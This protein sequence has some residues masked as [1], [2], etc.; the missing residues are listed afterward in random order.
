MQA[1]LLLFQLVRIHRYGNRRLSVYYA[2]VWMSLLW[3]GLRTYLCFQYAVHN[4]VASNLPFPVYVILFVCPVILQFATFSLVTL[5]FASVLQNALGG[6]LRRAWTWLTRGAWV[7]INIGVASISVYS[8]WRL[9]DED[10]RPKQANDMRLRVL[11]T[12]IFSI[13]NVLALCLVVFK[14]TAIP[15]PRLTLKC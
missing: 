9:N 2:C 11:V 12:E 10:E 15:A 14:V 5:Y 4:N 7:L 3:A 13:V 1:L 6:T 8:A